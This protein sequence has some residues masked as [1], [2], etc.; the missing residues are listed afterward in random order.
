[1]SG[2]ARAVP[3]LM[4]HHISTSPGMITVTP[5]HFAEQMAYL[6]DA[7]Y[8]TLGS[9]QLEAFLRGEDVP[10]K[11]LV[12][13]FDDGY[14]D[15]WV[16]AHPVLERHGL[17][18]LCFLVSSWPGAGDVRANAATSS[19]AHA[20]PRLLD[21]HEG[22]RAIADGRADDVILRWSEI[23]AMRHAGTFEFHSHTHSHVRWDQVAQSNEEKRE[24]LQ[25][26]LHEARETLAARLG[27]VS[28]H[29]CWPQGY[30]D[31]D[32]REIARNAGF[33]HFY[34]CHNGTNARSNA[35]TQTN[36][37][38]INRL[39]VRDKPATWLKSRLWV[40]SRPAISRAYL[41]IKR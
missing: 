22:E 8:R 7:G 39:E 6:A 25:Q 35:A 16:H 26:D 36:E 15:N 33:R 5:E 28:D 40:H 38:S 30:Y 20:L 9:A 24:R 14:L 31:D 13:T 1:M 34:T 41:K 11:S 4:Y 2:R 27:E 37:R 29:L 10:E 17:K 19:S 18:A 3:V 12:I 21:H 23:E 32:Y